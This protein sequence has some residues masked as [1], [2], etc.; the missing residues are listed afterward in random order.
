MKKITKFLFA[1]LVAA[2]LVCLVAWI[3]LL[4]GSVALVVSNPRIAE[5]NPPVAILSDNVDTPESPV[6]LP[7]EASLTEDRIPGYFSNG[8]PETGNFIYVDL[9]NQKIWAVDREN[10]DLKEYPILSFRDFGKFATP[11]GSFAALAK[12]KNHFSSI[13]KVW[14]PWSIQFHGDYFIHGW[15]EYQD[16]TLVAPGYSRGCVRL[17]T[18]D[19]KELWE[20]I[21]IGTEIIIVK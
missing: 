8:W 5:E 1:L 2:G 6:E 3:L 20:W 17:G 21:K 13:G 16:G 7:V 19:A 15:P 12:E 10:Q 11:T 9:K 4:V 18:N 14:M